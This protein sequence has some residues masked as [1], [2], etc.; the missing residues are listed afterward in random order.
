MPD[1]STCTGCGHPE[2]D[3]DSTDGFCEERA[4]TGLFGSDGIEVARWCACP[5]PAEEEPTPPADVP[6]LT[7]PDP[8]MDPDAAAAYQPPPF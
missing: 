1:L 3:D 6:R 5:G 2:H 8:W 7:I 4:G